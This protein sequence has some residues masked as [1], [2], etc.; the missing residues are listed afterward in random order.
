[1]RIYFS[2]VLVKN[3]INA[4][5]T[6]NAINAIDNTYEINAMNA[7]NAMNALSNAYNI[8]LIDKTLQT[9]IYSSEGIFHIK[10]NKLNRVIINDLP[11]EPLTINNVEFMVDRS[12][13]NYE[14]DWF[15]LNP[16]HMVETIQVST[17]TLLDPSA[18][19]DSSVDPFPDYT[20]VIERVHGEEISD[21][22]ILNNK[23]NI[24]NDVENTIVTFLSALNLC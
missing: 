7:T 23:N 11:F 9:R 4:V 24:D 5:D 16:N 8:Y 6:I 21:V 18:L 10:K 19:P 17:Y 20:L 22:Y 12:S 1:M 15:Q 13:I 3:M 14:V 2:D